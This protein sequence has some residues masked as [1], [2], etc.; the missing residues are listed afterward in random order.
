[1]ARFFT[2]IFHARGRGFPQSLLGRLLI[3]RRCPLSPQ[4]RRKS[5]HAGRSE[6][7]GK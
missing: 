1:M 2:S 7:G 3:N 5:G 6:K 4:K